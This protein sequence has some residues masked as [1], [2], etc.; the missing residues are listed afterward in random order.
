MRHNWDQVVWNWYVFAIVLNWYE[1]LYILFLF[2]FFALEI[3]ISCCPCT[4]RSRG[5]R[6][7]A[8]S[9]K[10][11]NSNKPLHFILYPLLFSVYWFVLFGVL[12][13]ACM[14]GWESVVTTSMTH[15]KLLAYIDNCWLIETSFFSRIQLQHLQYKSMPTGSKLLYL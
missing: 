3:S 8:N 9:S 4:K 12:A 10:P 13:K 7:M 6:Q 5:R 11:A 14:C 1:I 2:F 15:K